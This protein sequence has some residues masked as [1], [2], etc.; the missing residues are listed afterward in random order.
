MRER[1]SGVCRA[2]EL[3]RMKKPDVVEANSAVRVEWSQTVRTLM[4][5]D[6]WVPVGSSSRITRMGNDASFWRFLIMSDRP[7]SGGGGGREARV[8]VKG[9]GV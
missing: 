2:R 9:R 3:V 5:W 6:V 4:W 7:V 8:A 1:A